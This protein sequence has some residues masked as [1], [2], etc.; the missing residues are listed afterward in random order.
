MGQTTVRQKYEPFA[1]LEDGSRDGVMTERLIGTYLHG[2]L[3]DTR[4]CSALFG[5]ELQGDAGPEAQYAA[6]AD[7]FGRY[8]ERT[9]EWLP[10]AR[11]ATADCNRT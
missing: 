1:Q 11:S 10:S 6:L 9:A 7:W 3:E 4:V 2:A 5:I 8:A